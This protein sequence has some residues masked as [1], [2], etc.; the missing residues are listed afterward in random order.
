MPSRSLENLHPLLAYAFGKAEAQY[1]ALYPDEP[2]P[3]LSCTYRSNAEQT[4]LF[5]QLSDRIDNDGDGRIDEADEKVTNARAG[6]SPHNFDPSFAFDVAFQNKAGKT[7]WTTPQFHRFAKLVLLTA[8]ITWGGNFK[9]LLDLPHFELADWQK[10]V[11][12]K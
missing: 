8:G 11:S 10:R 12:K 7:D 5:N 2:R 3:F 4:S 6:Q 9:R 1:C